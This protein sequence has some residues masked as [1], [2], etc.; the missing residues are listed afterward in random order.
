VN[1]KCDRS[2]SDRSHFAPLPE[3]DRSTPPSP[4]WQTRAHEFI[5]SSQRLLWQ[6]GARPAQAALRY[7]RGRG[8][9]DVTIRHARLGVNPRARYESASAWG[10][11]TDRKVWLPRGIVIPWLHD[12]HAWGLNIRRPNGDL[13]DEGEGWEVRKYHRIL[14][15]ANALYNAD[16]IDGRPVVMVEGEFDA[17]AVQQESKQVAAVA[18]GSTAWAR[19]PRWRAL[20]RTTPR[21][22]VAFD[23]EEAG[24]QASRYW[25]RALPAATRWRPHLHDASAM[26]RAGLDV[27]RWVDEGL[28]VASGAALA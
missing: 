25:L 8:F 24:E 2:Q 1:G 18:T 22:L 11:D 23:A 15:S 19:K 13:K 17:L 9:S 3:R 7:L 28:D 26:L 14:G 4:A 20:L 27:A 21:V 12:G 6:D 10:L 5:N 16:E